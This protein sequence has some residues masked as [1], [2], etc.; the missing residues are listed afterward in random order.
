MPQATVNKLHGE[1][2]KIFSSPDVVKRL[3]GFGA[4]V[5]VTTAAELAGFQASATTKWAEVIKRAGI[6]P[7]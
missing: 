1:V 5:A 7:Q 2:V 4:E 6:T 3:A